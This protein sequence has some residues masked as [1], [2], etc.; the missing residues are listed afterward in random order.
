MYKRPVFQTIYNRITNQR[1]FIQVIAGP[2]QTG[3][4][5]LAR[6]ILSET[7]MPQHYATAD[8]P[9][10]KDRHWIQ[11]QWDT[12]NLLRGNKSGLLILDEIQKINGWSETVKKLWDED[13][14]KNN[15]L[16]VII[17]GS[18]PL[19]IQKGLTESLSGRFETIPVMHWSYQEM[20]AAFNWDIETYLH[21]GGYP[22][23]APLINDEERWRH[24]IKESLIETSISRDI[25]LMTR[26][27]K[28][29]LLRRLFELG[30]QY[31]GQIIS[32]Q[33]MIG[34]LQDAGNTTTLAHYLDLLGNAGFIAGVPKYAGEQFRRRASSP[35]LQVLNTALMTVSSDKSFKEMRTDPV[36][37]GR[38]F[39][40]AV[41]AHLINLSRQFSY[42]IYYW[43]HRNREVDFVL[44][45]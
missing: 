33:K 3:K 32:Y 27:D 29:A 31:S 26:V 13:S 10:S 23:S 11:Q 34:Q 40:S 14:I 2:R 6:Q 4:T 20:H 12:A 21:F 30:C 44:Q 18:S 24:Y 22:G 25:L 42:K 39:E 8:D 41:G 15:D 35:K 5:T 36:Y 28:P 1:Q 7:N 19:L 38:L 9:F 43:L 16:R 45:R 17:L 37:R